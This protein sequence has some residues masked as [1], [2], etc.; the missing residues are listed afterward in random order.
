MSKEEFERRFALN[1]EKYDYYEGLN[2]LARA[3][4]KYIN[5]GYYAFFL[6][7]GEQLL[8]KLCYPDEPFT[9]SH[10]AN[11]I[12]NL[13]INNFELLSHIDKTT[14]RK[15]GLCPYT[16]HR[17]NWQER[18]DEMINKTATTNDTIEKSLALIKRIEIK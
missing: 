16:T 17:G 1:K 13:N 18:A 14:L 15:S 3:R 6:P 5:N 12:F 2:Y 9:V 7:N 4:G 11:A 10:Y 8:D